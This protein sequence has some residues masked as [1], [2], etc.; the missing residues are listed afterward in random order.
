ML[1][2][3][4]TENRGL[5]IYFTGS[6]T[7]R[8]IIILHGQFPSQVTLMKNVFKYM[9]ALTIL[10]SGMTLNAVCLTQVK[11]QLSSVKKSSCD[12]EATICSLSEKTAEQ[13]ILGYSLI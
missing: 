6:M 1:G 11:L 2:L 8:S 12:G 5:K 9:Q 3:V 10:E 7:L 13:D 4:F